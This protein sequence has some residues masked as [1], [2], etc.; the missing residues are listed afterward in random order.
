M[1]KLK[2]YLQ[3]ETFKELHACHRRGFLDGVHP[4]SVVRQISSCVLNFFLNRID[5]D[6]SGADLH[7]RSLHDILSTIVLVLVLV[8]HHIVRRTWLMLPKGNFLL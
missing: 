8:L 1:K 3:R 4:S 7:A 6:R 5:A 2:P